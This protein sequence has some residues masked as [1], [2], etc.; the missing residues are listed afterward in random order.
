MARFVVEGHIHVFQGDEAILVLVTQNVQ[1]RRREHIEQC[2]AHQLHRF[3]RPGQFGAQVLQQA[4]TQA[5][6]QVARIGQGRA[7]ERHI[8]GQTALEQVLHGTQAQ[9]HT[10]DQH[11]GVVQQVDQCIFANI[12]Q[13]QI[14]QFDDQRRRLARRSVACKL[15]DEGRQ[16]PVTQAGV[17][18]DDQ[19]THGHIAAQQLGCQRQGDVQ[20]THQVDLR[21]AIDQ[22]NLQ[23][24]RCHGGGIAVGVKGHGTPTHTQFQRTHREVQV[25]I[26]RRHACGQRQACPFACERVVVFH[27]KTHP[28]VGAGQ[29]NGQ[30]QLELSPHSQ[31]DVARARRVDQLVKAI[32]Q[33]QTVAG[34]GDQIGQVQVQRKRLVHP[35][36]QVQVQ[37]QFFL[38]GVQGEVQQ[39]GRQAQGVFEQQLGL[40]QAR[41]RIFRRGFQHAEPGVP[42]VHDALERLVDDRQGVHIEGLVSRRLIDKVQ[43]QADRPH[44]VGHAQLAQ[45]QQT[46]DGRQHQ[47][48]RLAVQA[49]FHG[50]RQVKVGG[51][52][53]FHFVPVQQILDVDAQLRLVWQCQLDAASLDTEALDAGRCAAAHMEGHRIEGRAQVFQA[54]A[55]AVVGHALGVHK[56][57]HAVGTGRAVQRQTDFGRQVHPR[58]RADTTGGESDKAQTGHDFQILDRHVHTG[59]GR[60]LVDRDVQRLTHP[61]HQIEAGRQIDIDLAGRAGGQGQGRTLTTK[62][63]L[64]RCGHHIKPVVKAHRDAQ[65]TGGRVKRSQV[66]R[67]QQTGSVDRVDKLIQ[68]LDLFQRRMHQIVLC[69]RVGFQG[70]R[71]AQGGTIGGHRSDLCRDPVHRHPVTGHGIG[72]L[73]GHTHELCAVTGDGGQAQSTLCFAVEARPG[74]RIAVEIDLVDDFRLEAACQVQQ[75]GHGLLNEGQIAQAQGRRVDGLQ[76]LEHVGQGRQHI[77]QVELGQLAELVEMLGRHRQ[78]AVENIARQLDGGCGTG[79]L[80]QVHPGHRGVQRQVQRDVERRFGLC[81][82][83][84]GRWHAGQLEHPIDQAER[85]RQGDGRTTFLPIFTGAAHAVAADAQVDRTQTRGQHDVIGRQVT[86]KAELMDGELSALGPVEAEIKVQRGIDRATHLGLSHQLN[87]QA[88]QG[89]RQVQI[90]C[91]IA[92]E[93]TVKVQ[94]KAIAAELAD[95]Q[96]LTAGQVLLQPSGVEVAEH[97]PEAGFTRHAVVHGWQ[98]CELG[99]IAFQ[100]QQRLQVVQHVIAHT[101]HGRQ[102]QQLVQRLANHRQGLGLAQIGGR[103]AQTQSH[104]GQVQGQVLAYR[105]V[106]LAQCEVGV[107]VDKVQHQGLAA[108]ADA[109]VQICTGAVH[110]Q[111]EAG[112]SRNARATKRRQLGC[113][114]HGQRKAAVLDHQGHRAL[115]HRGLHVFG[116]VDR[117][118]QVG[119]RKHQRAL[120]FDDLEVTRTRHQ[121][122][123][124]HAVLRRTDGQIQRSLCLQLG[125]GLF[126]REG[127][128]ATH[129]D[130]CEAVVSAVTVHIPLGEVHHTACQGT[131]TKAGV[132]RQ[133]DG[134]RVQRHAGHALQ[135]QA[136]RTGLQA[137]E[138]AAAI[139]VFQKHQ[140]QGTVLQGH[141]DKTAVVLVRVQAHTHIHTRGCDGGQVHAAAFVVVHRDGAGTGAGEAKS[142]RQADQR[143]DLHRCIGH[144]RHKLTSGQTVVQRDGGGLCV[145]CARGHGDRAVIGTLTAATLAQ[146]HGLRVVHAALCAQA[147]IEL[148]VELA[149]RQLDAVRQAHVAGI[150]IDR[151]DRGRQGDPAARVTRRR[152]GRCHEHQ[153][154]RQAFDADAVEVCRQVRC[155]DHEA[156]GVHQAGTHFDAALHLGDGHVARDLQSVAKG[157]VHGAREAES[158]TRHGERLARAIAQGHQQ[159]FTIVVGRPVD[160]AGVGAAIAEAAQTQVQVQRKMAAHGGQAV[161]FGANQCGLIGRAREGEPASVVVGGGRAGQHQGQV[162]PSQGKAHRVGPRPRGHTGTQVGA[163]DDQQ[164]GSHGR[165][166][167]RQCDVGAELFDAHA[168]AQA[169]HI[170]NGHVH[171][172]LHQQQFTFFLQCQVGI[173]VRAHTH[174]VGRLARGGE[175]EGVGVG[176]QARGQIADAVDLDQEVAARQGDGGQTHQRHRARAGRQGHPFG[177]GQ[178]HAVFVFG[179]NTVHGLGRE[180]AQG[181]VDIAHEK[182]LG[183]RTE[184][185][186]AVDHLVAIAVHQAHTRKGVDGVGTHGQ[187][188]HRHSGTIGQQHLGGLLLKGGGPVQVDITVQIDREACG[189]LDLLATGTVQCHL[190][191]R[192]G[193]GDHIKVHGAEVQHL[194]RAGIGQVDG[195]QHIAHTHLKA[196]RQTNN[197]GIVGARFQRHAR[198]CAA[199]HRV[200][201]GALA[202]DHQTKV[203]TREREAHRVVAQGVHRSTVDA[204]K[205]LQVVATHGQHVV[206]GLAAVGQGHHAGGLFKAQ[207]TACV[208]EAAQAD[209]HI[210]TGTDQRTLVTVQ[211]QG[212]A[213]AWPCRDFK[214]CEVLGRIGHALE[215]HHMVDHVQ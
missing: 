152:R 126:Q 96:A 36:R 146:V 190:V 32:G 31:V 179:R 1:A 198:G 174:L 134:L 178:L 182:A 207:R 111:P 113:S 210:G 86:V 147:Q 150:H 97:A 151:I 24:G 154:Q 125:T 89:G 81:P 170:P 51:V 92:V 46:V 140:T 85:A 205:S 118:G 39:F 115:G 21:L 82:W 138:A 172:A 193:A 100:R 56:G 136:V 158:L 10:I 72:K 188:V 43:A 155:T 18:L 122:R 197:A 61:D 95:R 137:Q 175:V 5:T 203:H 149:G 124:V 4:A 107:V 44:D 74:D 181:Q 75:A 2:L 129:Q 164:V 20:R 200:R 132:H 163:A 183:V 42:D 185:I 214:R 87:A 3:A 26:L 201:C 105:G 171:R 184:H 48:H 196:V 176:I 14:G 23:G 110:V 91:H 7:Q 25:H 102:V 54:K 135:A 29:T 12:G 215:V 156:G 130:R 28:G 84:I 79:V 144:Q 70:R 166:I 213:G 88:V 65:I 49:I 16:A 121:R 57:G 148:Q 15:V 168:A 133:G 98:V 11:R 64:D 206:Q 59:G 204:C 157:Q 186:A 45:V 123:R 208:E 37:E 53:Q 145:G 77:G 112:K 209:G 103:V 67:A 199:C 68:G 30:A 27:R 109:L 119:P 50:L 41:H 143:T 69:R 153:A 117:G 38:F 169:E 173:K 127:R 34:H 35:Q 71:Q 83:L 66:V 6:N 211:L 167:T 22:C 161:G 58:T 90:K 165:G 108:D 177:T 9:V 195:H 40:V 104:F 191:S 159:A 62:T 180:Q 8:R 78:G 17:G 189:H 94:C 47:H 141:T 55:A 13:V 192:P 212:A 120:R 60:E 63:E 33:R 162:Q 202:G 73:S 160:G 76:V 93:H 52:L 139:E 131:G 19:L 187:G 101:Q 128:L 116:Q 194:V 114:A 80:G 142:A 106:Q 99:G